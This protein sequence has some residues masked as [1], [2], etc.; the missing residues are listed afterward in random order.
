[1][2]EEALI[3]VLQRQIELNREASR[4]VA[5]LEYTM[6]ALIGAVDPD[7]LKTVG[8]HVKSQI[9][10]G[11]PELEAYIREGMDVFLDF[12]AEYKEAE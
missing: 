5:V 2:A 9:S 11:N 3:N 12:A 4:R 6:L 7:K 1:M 10:L 8:E